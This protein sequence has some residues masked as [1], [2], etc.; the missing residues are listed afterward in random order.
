MHRANTTGASMQAANTA[1]APADRSKRRHDRR[2]EKASRAGLPS[3]HRPLQAPFSGTAHHMR[4][5]SRASAW[6]GVALAVASCGC[7]MRNLARTLGRGRGE[8]RASL[9][10]PILSAPGATFPIPSARVGGRYGVTD[11]LDVD[12]DFTL[13]PSVLGVL[14]I[15]A[16][17]VGQIYREPRDGFALSA[18][19]HGYF[20]V[21]LSDEP[22]P[23]AFPELGLHA[24][25]RFGPWLTVFGGV[26]ALAQFDPPL[27]KPPVFVAP[28]LGAELWVD[29]SAPTRHGIALQLAWISPWED[30]RSI[31]SWEPTGAGVFV[32]I[33]GWR[34]VFGPAGE[35]GVP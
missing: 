28:Y 3:V 11:W 13:D 20:F 34:A 24:E 6:L 12:G 17:L 27:D 15:D 18:S 14:A 1:G 7:G 8:L 21:D 25:Y 9:G 29:P 10:G 31:A 4:S 30:F 23:R 5:P 26:V 35:P 16:G 33:I 2:R 19:A 22:A 32:V